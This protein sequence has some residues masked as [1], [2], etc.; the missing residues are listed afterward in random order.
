MLEIR[1]LHKAFGALKVTDD[2]SLTV[3][4]GE[5]RAVIG[6]NGAGKTSLLAQ[7]AGELAPDRGQILFGERDVTALS[8]PKRRREGISRTYQIPSLL[9]GF[10]ALDNARLAVQPHA[11]H[12]FRFYRDARE[13]SGLTEPALALLRRVGLE[14]RAHVVAGRLAHGEQRQLELA[15]ALAGD[16]R[17]LLLDEPT[18][19]MGAED[20]ARMTAL[21]A[22]IK[23]WTSIILVEHDM[24]TVFAVADRVTVLVNG[25]EILTGTPAEVRASEEVRTSY[26]GDDADA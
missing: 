8:T 25:G 12:S 9:R 21:I 10:S 4:D 2:L 23:G 1:N 16:P 26:L 11:G 20:C 7:I 17:L 22:S 13:E 3:A 24:Q 19:G 5:L 18:A 14:G 6:P 15:M